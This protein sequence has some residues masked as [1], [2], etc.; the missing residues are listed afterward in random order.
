MYASELTGKGVG[1]AVLDTGIALHKDFQGR[2]KGFVDFVRHKRAPY[3]D[4]GH[5]THVTGILA[6]SGAASS[7]KYKGTAPGAHLIGMKVLDRYGN[8]RKEDVLQAFLWLEKHYQEYQIRIVNISV[9]TTCNTWREHRLLIAGVEQLWDKGLVVVAAAGNQGPAPGSITAPG[10]SRKII[11]VGSSDMIEDH[12]GIS[13]RGPTMECICKPDIVAPGHRIVSCAPYGNGYSIKSGTSMSTPSVS[14]AIALLLEREPD[15][16][17][18]EI[19]KRLKETAVDLGLSH[20]QQGWGLF[21]L[22]EFLK[23]ERVLV[24]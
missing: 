18:V 3:D 22:E 23:K 9:G 1:V 8:G 19:K 6:G 21:S 15:L 5:G 4:N 16:T 7:G 12:Q 14:G 17:N 20:N 11:T 2:M 24:C 13:G 10:S